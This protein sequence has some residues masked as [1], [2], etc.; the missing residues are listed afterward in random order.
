MIVLLLRRCILVDPATREKVFEVSAL[1]LKISN[2][3]QRKM[4]VRYQAFIGDLVSDHKFSR[5]VVT[6][7][8]QLPIGSQH[9]TTEFVADDAIRFVDL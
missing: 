9:I 3:L 6:P 8:I 1:N 2:P 5:I 7:H 4:S